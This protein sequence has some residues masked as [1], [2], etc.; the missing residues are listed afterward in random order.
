VVEGVGDSAFA[1][2]FEEPTTC[3]VHF[4]TRVVLTKEPA[5]KVVYSK[6]AAK[7]GADATQAGGGVEHDSGR[8]KTQGI[9]KKTE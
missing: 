6:L 3:L 5:Q 2:P 8:G 9:A 4:L 7:C 1:L